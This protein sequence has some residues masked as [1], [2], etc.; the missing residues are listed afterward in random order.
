[1][2]NLIEVAQTM[3]AEEEQYRPV[4]IGAPPP[5]FRSRALILGNAPRLIEDML[6]RTEATAL[7]REF[8]KEDLAAE[9]LPAELS[10]SNI[11]KAESFADKLAHLR[12]R[13]PETMQAVSEA[14]LQ[15]IHDR[16]YAQLREYRDPYEQAQRDAELLK[17]GKRPKGFQEPYVFEH[18][19]QAQ[20]EAAERRDRAYRG[21][22]F[23]ALP[24]KKRGLLGATAEAFRRGT[25]GIVEAPA[26]MLLRTL[27]GTTASQQGIFRQ[28]I[29]EREAFGVLEA[30]DPAG[31]RGLPLA[32]RVA[33]RMLA[34]AATT[35]VAPTAG[36]AYWGLGIA[37]DEED[38]FLRQGIS[39]GK[40]RIAA[41]ASGAVQAY[42]ERAQIRGLGPGKVAGLSSFLGTQAKRLATE[43]LEEG[44]Q[45]LVSSAAEYLAGGDVGF[46]DAT[47]EAVQ[48]TLST[49]TAMPFLMI[50]G[51]GVELYG[52]VQQERQLKGL[53]TVDPAA[54]TD[55]LV[56]STA[57][58]PR[59]FAKEIGVDFVR[60]PEQLRS[61]EGIQALREQAREAVKTRDKVTL[62]RASNA[63]VARSPSDKMRDYGRTVQQKLKLGEEPE[64]GLAKRVLKESQ[65][66]SEPPEQVALQAPAEPGEITPPPPPEGAIRG[67]MLAAWQDLPKYAGSIN[68]ERIDA[69]KEAKKAI[70]DVGEEYKQ[71]IDDARRGTQTQ[72]AT[73][74]LADTLGMTEE[75]LLA[76][77]KGQA[78]NAEEA[79]AARDILNTS[80]QNL[81]A[82]TETYAQEQT[83]QNLD[84]WRKGI[85]RHAMIQAQVAGIATEAGR[86]LAAHKIQSRLTPEVLQRMQDINLGDPAEVNRFVRSVADITVWD[87][88]HELWLN[89]LLSGPR[90]HIV[91]TTS[92]SLVLATRPLERLAAAGIEAGRAAVT[93]APRQRFAREAIAD[94]VGMAAGIQEGTRAF[95]KA[96]KEQLSPEVL[97]KMEQAGK[98]FALPGEAGRV[99]RIPVRLLAAADEFFKSVNYSGELYAAATRTA[100]QEGL[101]GQTQ[102]D[103]IAELVQNP[104]EAMIASAKQEAVYRTFNKPLGKFGQMLLRGRYKLPGLRYIVPF[105][106]TPSNIAKYALERTPLNF[107]RLANMLRKGELEGAQISDEFSRPVIGSLILAGVVPLVKA[108]LITGGGPEDRNKREALYRTGWQPYAFRVGDTW[109]GYGRLEPIGSVFGM[110]ADMV[111][112]IE[113][114]ESDDVVKEVILGASLSIGRN[115]TSKT[116]MRGLAD[117][118]DATRDPDKYGERLFRNYAR[119]LVP[120]AVR[121]VK[122]GLD[123][124]LVEQRTI[125]DA[126]AGNLPYLSY[127]VLPR[128]DV[129]GREIRWEGHPLWRTLSPFPIKAV[130]DDPVDT[131]LVRLGLSPGL[132]SRKLREK[133]KDIELDPYEYDLYLRR[134]GQR[135]Y[136]KAARIVRQR[137]SDDE[138]IKR[139]KAALREARRIERGPILRQRRRTTP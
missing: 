134:S 44:A 82:L 124:R 123:A 102:L 136:R 135:A 13:Y 86:A 128:R 83:P 74:A 71:Y 72:Q 108:G 110:A 8:R 46:R 107:L 65:K 79:L 12:E 117:F 45:S 20:R 4:R 138:K 115:I 51:G 19:T 94:F 37:R 113:R 121:T 53:E 49:A 69:P 90:T 95:T 47:I 92:N 34:G 38:K 116:F 16:T 112:L 98:R 60:L 5:D 32:A 67:G 119:S 109:I 27:V 55:S 99:A 31:T 26:E 56:K 48:E 73:R 63:V 15:E 105:M 11:E 6:E 58:T 43:S 127:S 114:G 21:F 131:E 93:R 52:A 81:V 17:K 122:E 97:T 137:I 33:P 23:K 57:T 77:R 104:T 7:R 42:I 3:L 111:E 30:R 66:L 2:P 64:P 76:R 18:R 24:E 139:I 125:A 80:G 50:P 40:A 22:L 75:S 88:I 1:V 84:A 70:L 28:G 129:W 59:S 89:F 132:P 87:Q 36:L 25:R 85:E 39:P 61:S 133:G 100:L 96:W 126:V 9:E 29:A 78:F 14:V 118:L 68:L 103:R 91:N 41:L 101:K 35:A 120:A 62:E 106:R 54:F 10:L 130:K